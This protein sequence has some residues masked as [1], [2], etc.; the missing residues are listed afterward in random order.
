MSLQTIDPYFKSLDGQ[1]LNYLLRWKMEPVDADPTEAE[2]VSEIKWHTGDLRMK[3]N[4]DGSTVET[5]AWLSDLTAFWRNR[6][7]YGTAGQ[8]PTVTDATVLPGQ[9]L[10]P[11]DTFLI[12]GPTTVPGIQGVDD[13]V[14]GDILVFLGGTPE[15][16]TN[17]DQWVGIR[18]GAAAPSTDYEQKTIS[19]TA[20]TKFTDTSAIIADIKDITV[21]DPADDNLDITASLVITFSGSDYSITGNMSLANLMVTLHGSI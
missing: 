2:N 15:D 8:L 17:P 10:S 3:V 4:T 6:G 12:T 20:D 14:L 9:A 18:Q 11:Y 13:L 1:H 19:I 7:T 21:R 5:V 16:A